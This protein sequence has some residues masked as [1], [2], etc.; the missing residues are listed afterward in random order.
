MSV[1]PDTCLHMGI[2]CPRWRQF[3]LNFGSIWAQFG[4]HLGSIWLHFGFVLSIQKACP[5]IEA[6]GLN[7]SRRSTKSGLERNLWRHRTGSAFLFFANVGVSRHVSSYFYCLSVFSVIS[8]PLLL[9]F[10]LILALFGFIVAIFR[11]FQTCVFILGFPVCVVCHFVEFL[12]HLG[13]ML[14]PFWLHLAPCWLH[15]CE[16]GCPKEGPKKNP[17]SWIFVD[18]GGQRCTAPG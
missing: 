16:N 1:F 13:S 17:L 6:Q 10:G 14:A 4:L 9:H 12:L 18:F 7:S 5:F 2:A 11:C 3:W 15:F 8:V